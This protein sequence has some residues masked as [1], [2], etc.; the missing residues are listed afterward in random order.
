MLALRQNIHYL[1]CL[2]H[3]ELLLSLQECFHLGH[4][5]ATDGLTRPHL[6]FYTRALKILASQGCKIDKCP[7]NP[8]HPVGLPATRK[9]NMEDFT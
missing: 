5:S 9:K 1:S 4:C 7:I 3:D 6:A 2:P 8:C